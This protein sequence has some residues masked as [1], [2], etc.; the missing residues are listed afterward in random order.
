MKI[1]TTL[2]EQFKKGSNLLKLIYINSALFLLFAL[3]KIVTVL[4]NTPD[5]ETVMLG[6][7][8]TPASPSTLLVRPWTL[9]TYMFLHT[10]FFHLLFNMLWLW[11]F[12]KIFTDYFNQK[13]II[14][15]YLAGGLAGSLLYVISFNLFPGFSG[16]VDISVA[17]GASAAVMAIVV[18]T[19]VYV[20]DYT[21][22]LLF[23]GPVKIKW[24]AL[25]IFLL[26]SLVDFSVNSG[27]KIAHIGGA[28][29]GYLYAVSYRNGK[30]LT[31]GLNRI[32]DS[33]ATW[34]K[35][36]P[37]MT[38]TYKKP[39]S[40]YEYNKTRAGHQE[41]INKILEKI[42]RGGYDS[43]TREEKEILFSESQKKN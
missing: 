9:I 23:L 38:V 37:N 26:T 16:F 41:K 7:L 29:F 5:L 8:A 3:L 36:R 25:A 19:A 12:G 20:P 18:A 17:L 6:Y 42:S 21:I 31:K 1:A 30:D 14:P 28:A 22:Y 13:R 33:V 15:V 43:L 24:V 10:D 32:L 4:F 40:D 27:G 39:M 35:P 11:W 2:K 34:F